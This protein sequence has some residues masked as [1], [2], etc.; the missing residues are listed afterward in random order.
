MNEGCTGPGATPGSICGRPV[1]TGALCVGHYKQS[2]RHKR[3]P[4]TPLRK[5][6]EAPREQI[7]PVRVSSATY[8]ALTN[9]AKRRSVPV[10]R[11]VSDVLDTWAKRRR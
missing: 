10:V 7:A 1:L 3:T 9:E 5:R 4:L 6:E 8:E 2:R 11:V